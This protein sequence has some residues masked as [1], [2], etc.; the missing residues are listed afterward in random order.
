MNFEFVPERKTYKF[1]EYN[2]RL[3]RSMSQEERP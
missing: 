2:D 3:A 1:V